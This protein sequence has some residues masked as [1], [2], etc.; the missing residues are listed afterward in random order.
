MSRSP[1]DRPEQPIPIIGTV[2]QTCNF[3][4]KIMKG[5]PARR[6]TSEPAS[7]QAGQ[8]GRGGRKGSQP[9]KPDGQ[10][11]QARARARARARPGPSLG[12]GLP[13]A[14]AGPLAGPGPGP[15]QARAQARAAKQE[16]D[17]GIRTAELTVRKLKL[18]EQKLIH[19]D[20]RSTAVKNVMKVMQEQNA[21]PHSVNRG[22]SER[23]YCVPLNGTRKL[24]LQHHGD[25]VLKST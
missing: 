25:A 21:Q 17:L 24:R 2:H 5:R 18:F 19:Y 15:G 7:R 4:S 9:A 1:R 6:Q 14:R 16:K 8:D 10:P 13:R 12:L 3:W 20:S 22:S 23:M 11:G